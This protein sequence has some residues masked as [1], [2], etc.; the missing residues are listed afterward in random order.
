MRSN[1]R[2]ENIPRLPQQFSGKPDFT[3]TS[4][5]HRH[6]EKRYGLMGYFLPASAAPVAENP[7][8]LRL[9]THLNLWSKHDSALAAIFQGKPVTE[10]VQKVYFEEPPVIHRG[11]V[12]VQAFQV[13]NQ[14]PVQPRI[15]LCLRQ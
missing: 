4:G 11:G 15:W 5:I 14:Q 13:S 8:A 3:E 7:S 10:N 1:G 9:P 6:A 12:S 2:I